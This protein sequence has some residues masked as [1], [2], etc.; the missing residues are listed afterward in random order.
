MGY[1]HY[2]HRES[3]LSQPEFNLLVED[4]KKI[5]HLSN[6]PIKGWNGK[7]EPE[8]TNNTIR[9]NGEPSCETFSITRSIASQSKKW[10]SPTNNLYFNFCKTNREPYDTVV[11]ACLV[12]L[13]KH[14]PNSKISSDGSPDELQVGI[15]LAIK[16]I[17]TIPTKLF[18]E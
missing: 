2:W 9:F 12:A 14:F 7:G 13:K 11:V 5:I 18:E 10:E 1:T 8:L 17:E 4:V 3:I 16:A 15:N 6:I